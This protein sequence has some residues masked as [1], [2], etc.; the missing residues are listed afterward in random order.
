[1]TSDVRA[2][3]ERVRRWEAGEPWSAIYP[4][5]KDNAM[6]IAF[7]ERDWRDVAL[8]HVKEH[9]AG[10][11]ERITHA[12]LRSVGFRRGMQPAASN[13]LTLWDGKKYVT[14]H[15]N[16][17]AFDSVAVSDGDHAVYLP[18]GLAPQFRWELR[19]LCGAFNICF[20]EGESCKPT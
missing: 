10:D 11:D 2:A 16:G 17:T 5:S 18:G 9:P 4:E 12:W 20:R 15:S 19:T 3:A 6:A 7:L 14:F 13:D 8:A 1:M